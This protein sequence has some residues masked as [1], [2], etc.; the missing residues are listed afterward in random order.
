MGKPTAL[1]LDSRQKLAQLEISCIRG[2]KPG[3]QQDESVRGQ[4][5]KNFQG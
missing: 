2:V 4:K 3:S 5:K 1:R